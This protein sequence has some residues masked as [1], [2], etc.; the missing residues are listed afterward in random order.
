M[1]EGHKETGNKK[2]GLTVK[3]EDKSSSLTSELKPQKEN[4]G[5][6]SSSNLSLIEKLLQE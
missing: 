4:C 3:K 6:H 5:V 1:E 2:D